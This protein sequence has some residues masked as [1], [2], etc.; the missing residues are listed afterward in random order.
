P[1]LGELLDVDE[2]DLESD[3]DALLDLLAD[4]IADAERQRIGLHVAESSEERVRTALE[5]GDLLPPPDEIAA[6]CAVLNA[7]NVVAW[8]GW[9]YLAGIPDVAE[10]RE[11]SRRVPQL[12]TGVVVNDPL[13]VDR[14][15]EILAERGVLAH[16]FVAVGTTRALRDVD[17]R[18]P[19]ATD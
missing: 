8:T 9:D 19:D 6:V 14:A 12:S 16:M 4:V 5:N 3:V 13:Q 15:R 10:R 1:R 17:T 11:I 18:I 7:E 2:V